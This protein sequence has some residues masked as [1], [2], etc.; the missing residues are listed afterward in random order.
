MSYYIKEIS[1][2][3]DSYLCLI[4]FCM[5]VLFA[6]LILVDNSGV[7]SQKVIA[8]ATTNNELQL[9]VKDVIKDLQSR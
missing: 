3:S 5:G 6:F 2:Y 8:Q 9:L 4:L 7:V 1:Q